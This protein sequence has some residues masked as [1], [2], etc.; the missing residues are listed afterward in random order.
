M[1]K[2]SDRLWSKAGEMRI[3]LTAA[4][5][6]LPLCNLQCKMCYVRKSRTEVDS[7]GGLL[8]TEQWL[9][10][11]KQARDIGLLYPLLT[12][13]EP[14]LRQDFQEIL[15]SMK[16][17]GLQ[18]SINS[19]GTLIDEPM[20][21]WLGQHKP[22]RIN[23]TLYGASEESYEN[24]CGNG[25]AFRRVHQAVQWLKQNDVPVKFNTSITPE[26]VNDLDGMIAYARSVGS[27]IQV[28]TYMFPPVRRDASMIGQNDRLSPEEAAYARV[29][30]DYLQAN[31]DWFLGQAE[32]FSRYVPVTEKMLAALAKRPQERM[33]C[34]AG[35]CSFWIDWQ[36][37]IANCGMYSS[38]KHSLQ[39]RSLAEAWK[40]LVDETAGVR[41]SSYCSNCPNR[42]LCHACI[43]MVNNECGNLSGRPEYLCEMNAASAKYYAEYAAKLQSGELPDLTPAETPYEPDECSI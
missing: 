38:V 27:P 39:N 13:G 21:K 32:R 4:F 30:A 12:G 28:A 19:N 3:P 42:N 40:Q 34:R 22:V 23:I 41:Y 43:A 31:K 14:F 20:A 17:M 35:I 1:D 5:E 26:N 37:N 16:S 9:D 29:R 24:L 7:L 6:L 2:I 8:P 33:R 25:D 36:G 11:A 10:W 15:V 18:P